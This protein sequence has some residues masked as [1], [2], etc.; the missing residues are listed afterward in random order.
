MHVALVAHYSVLQSHVFFIC[1]SSCATVPPNGLVVYCGTIVTD[2]GKE[3]KV[4]IDFE[5][6][7]SINTSLYLCDNKFHTEVGLDVSHCQC[8][9]STW[10]RMDFKYTCLKPVCSL[11]LLWIKLCSWLSRRFLGHKHAFIPL[12]S[13]CCNCYVL[14][15]ESCSCNDHL[16]LPSSGFCR[17]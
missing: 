11:I 17:P 16:F 7:K 9:C 14:T 13:M 10:K 1:C 8:V 5:P 4:N 15:R 3:K 12:S 2:E 6:F